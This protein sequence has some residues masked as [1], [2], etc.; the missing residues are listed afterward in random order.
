MNKK[1]LRSNLYYGSVIL[2]NETIKKRSVIFD[3]RSNIFA[4]ILNGSQ[5]Y[6]AIGIDIY[7]DIEYPI[8]DNIFDA[9]NLIDK[10]TNGIYI[11]SSITLEPLLSFFGFPLELDDQAKID[12]LK[13][14]WNGKFCF[15]Y[16]E[17][18]GYK[19]KD[20]LKWENGLQVPDITIQQ[21]SD[22]DISKYEVI[23]KENKLVNY[24]KYLAAI[25]SENPNASFKPL[26]EEGPIRKRKLQG[27]GKNV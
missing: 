23:D 20:N 2:F 18:F 11:T 1:T 27:S 16:C 12:I 26:E 9:T 3:K 8:I 13:N 7:N 14:L 21:K 4:G 5:P 22:Y 10:K 15:Q 24:F 17:L 6:P 19:K 25:N